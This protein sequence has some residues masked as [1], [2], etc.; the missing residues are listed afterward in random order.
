M[1]ARIKIAQERLS[2]LQLAERL[3]NVSEACRRSGMDRASFY[4]W[5]RRYERDGIEGLQDRSRAHVS[6]PQT[7]PPKIVARIKALA[8]SHPA[9]GCDR[10]ASDLARQ[11][12]DVSAVTVQ[13]ILHRAGLGTYKARWLALEQNYQTSAA[14]LTMEQ[15][16]FVEK[17][18][19]AFKERHTRMTGPGALL[20]L[21]R[22]FLG[23]FEK[24]GAIYVHV[25]TDACSSYAFGL[26][27][28]TTRIET[29]L[30]LLSEDLLPFLAGHD[31]KPRRLA[32]V[33]SAQ[34]AAQ[35]GSLLGP[36]RVECAIGGSPNGY[37]L[38][39]REIV[40][41]EFRRKPFSRALAHASVKKLQTEFE[42]WLVFYNRDR[43]Q[44]GYPNYGVPPLQAIF[45][46]DSSERRRRKA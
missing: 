23:K 12:T 32:A 30:V 19:P 13:K 16:D 18:N 20:C 9:Y 33:L 22:F 38:R 26:V 40:A 45:R 3:G 2:V 31:I 15:S 27:S 14:R 7:T 25:I 42:S 34:D 28:E 37:M 21:D 44:P 35:V 46:A 41:E 24:A 29:T 5:R 10:I 17:L 43:P 36:A 39:F 11:G 4:V 6:H 8:W 1:D